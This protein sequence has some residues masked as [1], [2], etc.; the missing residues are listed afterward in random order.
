[1]YIAFFEVVAIVWIYGANRL[2]SNVREMTGSLPNLYIRGCWLVASPC[3]ILAIWI[4]SMADYEPPTYND[5]KY[6]FPGW[7]IAMGWVIASFSILAIPA[8]ALISV[9]NAKGESIAQVIF[10]FSFFFPPFFFF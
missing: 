2:A 7:S 1:M 8:F 4:F 10:F 6:K 3:L 5:G 9:I